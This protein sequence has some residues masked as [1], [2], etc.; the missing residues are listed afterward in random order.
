MNIKICGITRLED[1]EKAVEL[2]AWALGFLLWPESKRY[3]D[4]GVAAGIARVM[5]RKVE[6]VGV[7][8]NQPLDD[9]AALV[10]AIGL[11]YVQLHGDEGPSF[12]AAVSQRTG[13]KVIKAGRIIHAYDLR[14][15][16]R[17]HTDLHLLDTGTADG[18]YGGTGKTWDWSLVARRKSKIPFLLAGGLNPDNVAAAIAEANPWGIDVSSGVEYTPGVKSAKKL[19]ALFEA[20]GVVNVGG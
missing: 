9:I 15:M 2:G 6:L 11:T 20:A 7:F 3:V 19:E 18:T 12:C 1:A 4:P 5:R 8:V 16:D 10:D 13:A 14:E 17:Y